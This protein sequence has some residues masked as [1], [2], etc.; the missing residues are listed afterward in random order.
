MKRLQIK[1]VNPFSSNIKIKTK[2]IILYFPVTLT[3]IAFVGIMAYSISVGAIK[4]QSLNL[5]TQA[6]RQ[7]A[8]NIDMRMTSYKNMLTGF[9]FDGGKNRTLKGGFYRP[10]DELLNL[11][12][13][14]SS[15]LSVLST[16]EVDVNLTMVRF[17]NSGVESI[18]KNFHK[19]LSGIQDASANLSGY[20][21]QIINSDR[22]QDRTW[23]EEISKDKQAFL[24]KQLDD[25]KKY[26]Y[27]SI[28]KWSMGDVA[29]FYNGFYIL[30]MRIRDILNLPPASG[31]KL[32]YYFA[33]L[34]NSGDVLQADIQK[35]DFIR[36]HLEELKSFSLNQAYNEPLYL[37]GNTVLKEYLLSNGWTVLCIV[38]L[39]VLVKQA[40]AIGLVVLITCLIAICLMFFMSVVLANTLSIRIN[41]IC[42]HMKEFQKGHFNTKVSDI[43]GDEL[44]YLESAFN[45][46]TEN[47]NEL[48][49]QVF[50]AKLDIKEAQLKALQAQI[51]PHFLYN[52]LSSLGRLAN[53]GDKKSIN[54][55]VY[56]LA[57]F[58]RMTLNNGKDIISIEDEVKQIKAY[59]KIHK[60]R[61]EDQFEVTYDIDEKTFAY[62]TV[63]VI[64][65]PFIE[66]IFE[67]ARR[68]NETKPIQ[69]KIS[70]GFQEANSNDP[71]GICIEIT[72]TGI[73]MSETKVSNILS[74]HGNSS[75]YGIKNVHERIQLFYGSAFGV[76]IRSTL[77]VGTCVSLSIPKRLFQKSI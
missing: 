14:K 45:E 26:G 59:L 73:G 66:N 64:L 25:D 68:G 18:S 32:Q 74:G 35:Q 70:I 11:R 57:T 42:S 49:E 2:L 7:I 58:Y 54:E 52:S 27:Y 47:T 61:L 29:S 69:I 48:I 10:Y 33:V 50:R 22:I 21:V 55:M 56:A 65:Q 17:N 31:S 41:K 23:F 16:L 38:P 1:H 46:M 19:V 9:C 13:T 44:G 6:Q 5:A 72:D 51:N 39:S 77:G 53:V 34:D 3:L 8:G 30:T 67:H 20:S 12:D 63:K 71:D 24:F 75:G 60:I 40:E 37:E 28:I 4:E 76:K 43:S 62:Q 15:L 36:E